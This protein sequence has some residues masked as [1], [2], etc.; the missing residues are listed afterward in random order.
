MYKK[1]LRL[2]FDY[3]R[4]YKLVDM[5]YIDKL[6]EIVVNEKELDEY[7]KQS[8]IV[9]ADES[10]GLLDDNLRYT[11]AAY[12][13]YLQGIVVYENSVNEMLKKISDV[14]YNFSDI[15]NLFYKNAS[16]TQV[17]LHEIEHANQEKI[18]DEESSLESGILKLSSMSL[19]SRDILENSNIDY[20]SYATYL[21]NLRNQNYK[22]NYK[23]A[24]FERLAEIKSYTD[25]VNILS[26]I[27]EYVPNLIEYEQ[28]NVWSSSF[29]G[30]DTYSFSPTVYYIE[31]NAKDISN[32]LYFDWYNPN[33]END[34]MQKCKRK[35]S[36]NDRLKYGLMLDKDEYNFCHDLISKNGY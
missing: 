12:I 16:I 30:F 6:I 24:P 4:N 18:K 15:E 14:S 7:I 28:Y 36:I 32:N 19:E 26:L 23:Y 33:N 35:Y 8:K 27:K 21:V 25:I 5:N 31:R 13:P 3:S 34:S 10:D 20:I 11:T 2:L 1:I 9:G 17:V 22:E 29:R